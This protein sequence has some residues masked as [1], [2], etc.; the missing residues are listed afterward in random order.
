[1]N[2]RLADRPMIIDGHTHAWPPQDFAALAGL[3][4]LL[5]DR[6]EEGSP[7]NWTPRFDGRLETLVEEEQRAGVDRFVLLPASSRPERGR[8]LTEWAVRASL[9]HPEIIPFGAV[10][11]YS[12]HPELDLEVIADHGLRAVKLHSLV[13]RFDP[14]SGPALNLYGL[15]EKRGLA[16]LMDS[17]Y[18]AGATAVKPNLAVWVGAALE[19]GLETVPER[20]TQIARRFPG[21]KIIAAHLG[22]CYG[23][24][25]LEPLYGLDQ[26][27]FDLAY[28]HRLISPAR[29]V[30]IIR[31]KGADRIIWATDAPYR[32]PQN[33]LK[34]FLG[35]DLT[36]EEKERILARNLLDLLGGKNG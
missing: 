14:L 2:A 22:C 11:P 15:L 6:L 19:M 29:T 25:L 33:A 18:L 16:V 34:W 17:M 5:D 32:R 13:Q 21:L 12:P 28:V 26:V 1:M 4:Q 35:L 7:Y 30:E 31:A 8:E 20:I 9:E 23:W 3:G 27:W 10:H 36:P 24:H